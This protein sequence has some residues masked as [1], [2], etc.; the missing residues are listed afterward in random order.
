MLLVRNQ[1]S[2]KGVLSAE[3]MT[4]ETEPLTAILQ[5]AAQ[6][7]RRAR[8]KLYK[9]VYDELRRAAHGLLLRERRK[10]EMQTTALVNELV[11][12]FE[13]SDALAKMANRRIFFATAIRAMNHILIDH[14]RRRQKLVD[15]PDRAAVQLDDAVKWI[16]EQV[17]YDFEQLQLELEKLANES[18]RQHSVVMHRFFSGLSVKDT[19]D[20]LDVSLPTVERDWRLARAKLLR[21]LSEGET[22]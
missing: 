5:L 10:G 22:R 13:G 7:D 21:R 8:E 9:R 2:P 15:S 14:Y 3:R 16:E 4:D 1:N 18:P 19:A 12:R 11:L 17:G 6:D 20:I